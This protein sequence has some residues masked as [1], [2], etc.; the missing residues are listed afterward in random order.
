FLGARDD[1][2]EFL[3]LRLGH[4]EFRH[5]VVEVLTERSPFTLRDLEMFVRFA[6]GTAGVGLGAT[7]GPADHL[8]HVVLEARRADTVMR[9]INGSVR[10]QD[11]IVHNPIN[12]VVN[13]GSNRIDAAETLVERGLARYGTHCSTSRFLR[14]RPTSRKFNY[15]APPDCSLNQDG[16]VNSGFV[17]VEL[18]D[19]PQKLLVGLGRIG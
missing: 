19:R 1:G 6:H 7:R 9:L 13:Y 3:V 8:G 10:I 17:I 11:R 18:V 4:I 15:V 14:G 5:R 12:A 2:E 16:A